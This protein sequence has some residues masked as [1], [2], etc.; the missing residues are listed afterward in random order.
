MLMIE[1]ILYNKIK[2]NFDPRQTVGNT[3]QNQS[4]SGLKPHVSIKRSNTDVMTEDDAKSIIR[5]GRRKDFDIKLILDN[6]KKSGTKS[7]CRYN[8]YKRSTRFKDFDI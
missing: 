1:K 3:P 6:P 8:C 2:S 4:R 5:N 7:R